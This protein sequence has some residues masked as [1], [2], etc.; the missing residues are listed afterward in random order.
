M[1]RSPAGTAVVNRAASGGRGL[2]P[3]GFHPHVSRRA[4]IRALDFADKA[5]CL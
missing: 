2:G 5:F 1:M 3:A 4:G